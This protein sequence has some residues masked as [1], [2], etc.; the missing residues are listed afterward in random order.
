MSKKTKEISK[1]DIPR[2]EWEQEG[3]DEIRFDYKKERR[4]R[5]I[6]VAYIFTIGTVFILSGVLL[7]SMLF[8]KGGMAGSLSNIISE[9]CCV[10][11]SHLSSFQ[12]DYFVLKMHSPLYQT[13]A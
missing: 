13:S 7:F 8:Y 6:Y 5:K 4:Q 1:R 9:L 2:L 12:I 10:N 11:D 3:R